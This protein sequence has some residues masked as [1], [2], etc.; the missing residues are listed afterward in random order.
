MLR[1]N[2]APDGCVVKTAGVPQEIWK[3]RGPALVV[4]SQEQA[5]LHAQQIYQQVV[6]TKIMPLSNATQITDDERALIGR[7]FEGQSAKK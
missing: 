1:G 7:W 6:V 2:L 4:D 3:F 5:E